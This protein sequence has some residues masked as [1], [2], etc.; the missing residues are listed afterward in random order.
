MSCCS[1]SLRGWA[2]TRGID[3][4]LDRRERLERLKMLS[5]LERLDRQKRVD[6]GAERAGRPELHENVERLDS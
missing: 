6:E 3:E 5:R 2:N 4:R 1:R